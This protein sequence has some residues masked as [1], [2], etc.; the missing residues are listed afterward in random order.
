MQ[1]GST[2]GEGRPGCSAQHTAAGAELS[3][4]LP[5]RRSCACAVINLL[6]LAHCD[7]LSTRVRKSSFLLAAS[8]LQ[9]PEHKMGGG[10]GGLW[11]SGGKEL[12]KFP[13]HLNGVLYFC[14]TFPL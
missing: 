6:Q 1:A 4:H 11:E 2:A 14:T 8:P 10:E 9:H 7:Y 5:G 12:Q 13:T 3:A